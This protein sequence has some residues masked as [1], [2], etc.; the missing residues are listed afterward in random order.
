MLSYY[1]IHGPDKIMLSQESEKGARVIGEESLKRISR[2]VQKNSL[3][4]SQKS[5]NKPVGEVHL[6]VFVLFFSESMDEMKLHD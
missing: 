3:S 2:P 4:S 5:R 6:K 1:K